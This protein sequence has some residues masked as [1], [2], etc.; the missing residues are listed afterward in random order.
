MASS[1]YAPAPRGLRPGFQV[2]G[3]P[4]AGSSATEAGP[5]HR[6]AAGE[7]ADAFGLFIQRMC[8]PT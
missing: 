8:P 4:L 3:M 1:E 2:S 7:V 5:R 6:A